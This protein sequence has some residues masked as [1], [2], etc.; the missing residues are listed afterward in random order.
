MSKTRNEKE[1][2]ITTMM[3]LMNEEQIDLLYKLF[4]L[5]S[6]ASKSDLIEIFY[7][8]KDRRKIDTAY[9]VDYFRQVEN[10]YPDLKNGVHVFDYNDAPYG[11][12]LNLNNGIAGKILELFM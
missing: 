9:P 3:E 7:P 10:I 1:K 4:G 5:R 8:E 2:F 12:L 6:F 11:S